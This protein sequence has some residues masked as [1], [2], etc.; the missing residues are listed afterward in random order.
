MNADQYRA[1]LKRL[2]LSQAAAARFFG[3]SSVTARRWALRGE[4]PRAVELIL[5]VL[6][7]D[8]LTPDELIDPEEEEAILESLA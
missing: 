4:P 8:G 1:A 5:L 3:V 6:I 7:L 2:G